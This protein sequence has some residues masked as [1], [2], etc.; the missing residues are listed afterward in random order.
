MSVHSALQ[1][2]PCVHIK[3]KPVGT[4][5]GIPLDPYQQVPSSLRTSSP[6]LE[7]GDLA[8]LTETTLSTN[9]FSAPT[10]AKTRSFRSDPRSSGQRVVVRPSWFI[11]Q[12]AGFNLK[13]DPDCQR[14]RLR[15]LFCYRRQEPQVPS[16]HDLIR[17]HGLVCNSAA[18][19]ASVPRGTAPNPR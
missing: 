14:S 10:R 17:I 19:S 2:K 11:P 15:L 12:Q 9:S 16:L 5:V 3:S 7:P 1:G 4:L 18:C 13:I 8:C 6:W